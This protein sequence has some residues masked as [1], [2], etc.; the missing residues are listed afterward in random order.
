MF[1]T[2]KVVKNKTCMDWGG[3]LNKDQRVEANKSSEL[4][5]RSYFD[6]VK[7]NERLEMCQSWFPSLSPRVFNPFFL[8]PPLI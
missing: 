6:L 4:F 5:C 7:T 1:Y 2:E 8:N 3:I